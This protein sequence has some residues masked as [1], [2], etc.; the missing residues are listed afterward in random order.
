MSKTFR[1]SYQG[2]PW[3]NRSFRVRGICEKDVLN[4]CW[5]NRKDDVPGY[6]WASEP[7]MIIPACAACSAAAIAKARGDA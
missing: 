2:Q 4:P 3:R 5:D 6:H 7:G 1:V